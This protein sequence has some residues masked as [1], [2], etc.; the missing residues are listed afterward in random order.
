M[1]K[2][3]LA[4]ASALGYR[5]VDL[6]TWPGN[7]K[8]VPLYKKAGFF[9]VPETYVHMEDYV[10]LLLGMPA[11]A[12]FWAEADWYV[13]MVRDISVREDLILDGKMRVYPYEFR[14]GDRFV[15]ATIDATARGLTALETE[16]WRVACSI[17]DRTLI[18]GRP[19]TVRWAV[20]NRTGRP[21]ALSLLAGA[22]EGLHLAKKETAAVADR[23]V[24][25]APLY[26]D[27]DS[28]PPVF[29]RRA[30][31]RCWCSMGSPPRRAP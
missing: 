15:R 31:N 26:T 21:L 12:D 4:H 17:D 25:E 10:P 1:L 24:A 14:H 28:Q 18:A 2:A 13:A 16:R 5:R 22:G 11:L 8:A 7:M 6:G 29:G 9:W 23:Y 3:A 19:R 27:L 20:E 30:W